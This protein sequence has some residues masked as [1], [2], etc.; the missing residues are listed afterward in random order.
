MPCWE[1]RVKDDWHVLF[2]GIAHLPTR[3][4]QFVHNPDRDCESLLCLRLLDQSQ[5]RVQGIEHDTLAGSGHVAE[6]AAFDRIELGAVRRIVRYTDG[7]THVVGDTLEVFLE[8]MFVRAVTPSA[9]TQE[10]D[11]GSVWVQT[12]TIAVPKQP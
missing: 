12:L 1:D 3:L 8:Q 7:D 5:H 10:Q 9:I 6:Q 11:G 4:V 2:E